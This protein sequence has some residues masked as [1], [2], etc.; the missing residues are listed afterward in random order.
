MFDI[1]P[2]LSQRRGLKCIDI[3]LGYGGGESAPLH[4]ELGKRCRIEIDSVIVRGKLSRFGL[5]NRLADRIRVCLVDC[6]GSRRHSAQQRARSL[7]GGVGVVES[8]RG[9][10][11]RD[12]PHFDDL[13]GYA[14]IDTWLVIGIGDPMERRRLGGQG[15]GRCKRTHC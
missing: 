5:L 11:I 2:H 3:L 4:L 6:P 12:F 7:Q 13:L 10:I 9:R 15:A 14:L 1:K 8:R